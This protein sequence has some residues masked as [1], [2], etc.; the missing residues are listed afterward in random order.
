M[1]NRRQFVAAGVGAAAFG[2]LGA[3][4]KYDLIIKGGRVIDPARKLEFSAGATRY[5]MRGWRAACAI[6]CS[7]AS[8]A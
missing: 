4:A 1:M 8:V 7:L 5:S 3:A 6:C 2:R